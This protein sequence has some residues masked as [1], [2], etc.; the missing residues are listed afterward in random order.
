M[1]KAKEVAETLLNILDHPIIQEMQDR[2]NLVLDETIESVLG[3]WDYDLFSRQPSIAYNL[4]GNEYT[5]LDLATF[6]NALVQRKAVIKIPQYK[7]LRPETIKDNEVLIEGKEPYGVCLGLTSNKDVFSFGVRIRDMRYVKEMAHQ[8]FEPG[9][10]R[11][12]LVTDMD[13]RLYD[14]WKKIEFIP[15]AN[16]ND[17]LQN[18]ALWPEN[19]IKFENFAT[20]EKWISLYGQYYFVAKV[21]I[22]RL[23]NERNFLKMAIEAL[24]DYGVRLPPKEITSG[25]NG[26]PEVSEGEYETVKVMSFEA[27]VDIPD[28]T[29]NY[30]II[31]RTPE[32]LEKL[33]LKVKQLNKYLERLRFLTRS[34]ELAFANKHKPNSEGKIDFI[35]PPWIKNFGWE[36]DY[37]PPKRRTK[38]YRLKIL[39]PGPGE[40]SVAIRF[41]WLEKTQKIR[42]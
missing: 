23:V 7:Q 42:A 22:N 34:I 8:E 30:P 1:T 3:F 39:Q 15:T 24:R 21:V 33:Y 6:F 12:Y 37:R 40:R 16:E 2:S 4:D 35:Y 26:W 10:Y 13:G 41:R 14:G 17:F 29:R 27:E 18:K 28:D 38:W 20:Q 31:E 36:S 25:F 11:T 5:T 19:S 32:N 9:S